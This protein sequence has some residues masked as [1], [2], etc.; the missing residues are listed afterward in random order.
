M[1]PSS[2]RLQQPMMRQGGIYLMSIKAHHHALLLHHSTQGQ[3]VT[4][5]PSTMAALAS[6]KA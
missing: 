3:R 4:L 2:C 1:N 5:L 6:C